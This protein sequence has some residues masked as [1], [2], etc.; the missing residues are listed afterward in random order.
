MWITRFLSG[1][2]E[3]G[4]FPSLTKAFTTWLPP[5]EHAKTQGIMWTFAR[6]G[7]AFTPV[8]VVLVPAIRDLA[9]RLRDLRRA[10]HRMG[11]LL[12]CLIPRR[13]AP[14]Q[15]GKCGRTSAAGWFGTP[16]IRSRECALG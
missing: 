4:C 15:R 3:A 9:L 7:G 8:L 10:R 13:S 16:R 12:L 6:W 14:A 1:V 2:G 5:V 11:V